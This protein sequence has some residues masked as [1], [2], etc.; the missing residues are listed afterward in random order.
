MTIDE[1]PRIRQVSDEGDI[2][3]LKA[4]GLGMPRLFLGDDGRYWVLAEEWR[5]WKSANDGASGT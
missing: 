3:A 5:A 1:L 4:G 2:A